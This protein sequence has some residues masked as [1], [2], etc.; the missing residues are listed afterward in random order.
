[1]YVFTKTQK[2][3][4]HKK[5]KKK[6][7]KQVRVAKKYIPISLSNKDR[8]SIS[9]ELRRSRKLY[10]QNK[11]Y[12]RKKVKSFKQKPSKHVS[13]A[14]KIYNVKSLKPTRILAKKTGCSIK[15]L[16]E[17]EKKGMGA[18]YSSGS[19]PNQ[20]AHSWGRAR[21]ASA[22]TGGKSAAV[23]FH[24]IEKGCNK[25][26][27]AYK[28]AVTSQKKHNHGQRRTPKTIVIL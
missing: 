6:L 10:K 13:K 15:A 18:Y 27:K 22:I 1:M 2:H 14:M 20:T 7:P 25:T 28:L 3:K 23:D 24:I 19:R 26:K 9:R 21:L 17:I 16:R 4:K 12:T 5:H 8:I 11:Y